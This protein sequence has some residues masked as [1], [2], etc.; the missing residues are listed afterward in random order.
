MNLLML[1]GD[2]S[3]ARGR[4]GAFD[5]ML[6]RF[7]RYWE[8][9]DI[10]T[11]HAP[12]GKE[13]GLYG[14]IFVHPSPYK[15]FRQ[16]W[17]IRDRGAALM[18]ER[19]Y[20]LITS[21][22]FGFFYN[23]IGAA[24][25]SRKTGVPYVSEIHHVEGYPR[26]I[27]SRERIYRALAGPYIRFARSRAAAF[28]TVNAVEVPTLLRSLG[29]PDEKILVLPSLYIDFEVFRPLRDEQHYYDVVAVGR[30]VANKGLPT[31]IDA[32]ARVKNNLPKVRLGILGRG[33]L[34]RDLREQIAALGLAD[35]VDLHTDTLLQEDV[36]R[37]YNSGKMLVCASTAEGGPRVTVEAMACAVPVISTPVGVMP[38]L[39]DDGQNGL[40]F[41][42]DADALAGNILLLLSDE[43]LRQRIG[44]AG[45]EA[46]QP[47]Q[48]DA[49]IERY[50]RGYQALV[51]RAKGNAGG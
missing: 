4:E 16:P 18:A 48:A 5:A 24:W 6:R 10:L 50:A 27:T 30:L 9:I 12:G 37:F 23:G 38:E 40:L 1:S 36:V 34:E 22:D 41:N 28:R 35:N 39:I 26:A 29:V 14:N 33:P 13:R 46:V 19:P 44:N 32:I 3:V 42:W 7:S 47:F 15:R 31:L 20:A 43:D 21:H 49:V 2:T 25:L 51:A 8:R 17:Y 11:P 45:R